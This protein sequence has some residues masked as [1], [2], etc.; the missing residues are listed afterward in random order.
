MSVSGPFVVVGEMS[1]WQRL[2]LAPDERRLLVFDDG[3]LAMRFALGLTD[4][5]LDQAT[6]GD[7]ED[8]DDAIAAVL[9]RHDAEPPCTF[10]IELAAEFRAE[11]WP[12][13]AYAYGLLLG[14][15]MLNAY[16]L[17]NPN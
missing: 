10:E 15:R 9:D 13:V 12:Q 1:D 3:R 6:V 11:D 4:V 14:G 8:G 7:F 16:S 5:G 2:A 17:T